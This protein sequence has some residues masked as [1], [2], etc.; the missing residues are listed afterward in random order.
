MRKKVH[1]LFVF[2]AAFPGSIWA[3]DGCAVLEK[4]KATADQFPYRP[5]PFLT[6]D[7]S[8]GVLSL[9]IHVTRYGGPL[10]PGHTLRIGKYMV[11]DVPVFRIAPRDGTKAAVFDPDTGKPVPVSADCLSDA[12]WIFGGTRWQLTQGDRIRITLTS[13]LDYD[14]SSVGTVLKKP[15]N[16]SVPCRAT[17]LHTHGFLVRPT[18]PADPTGLYGDYVLDVTEQKNSATGAT[19]NCGDTIMDHGGHRI[20]PESLRY[21]IAIPGKPGQNGVWTGEHPS[22]LFWYHPH[23][24]GFSRMQTGGGTTGLI[25]IGKLSEYACKQKIGGANCPPAYALSNIRYL[26]LKDAQLSHGTVD[27]VHTLLPEYSTDGCK[28]RPVDANGIPQNS[29]DQTR[30][31]ECAFDQHSGIWVFT[32]NGVQ[33]PVITDVKWN[34][35]EV[36]RIANTSANASY[37]LQL[38]DSTD[39]SRLKAMQVLALDGVSVAQSAGG[40]SMSTNQVLLMPG[41]R[42]EVWL[43]PDAGKTYILRTK[44]INTGSNG[45]GDRWADVDLAEVRWPA[46]PAALSS[47]GHRSPNTV[48]AAAQTLSVYVRGPHDPPATPPTLRAVGAKEVPMSS[49]CRLDAGDERHIL[50]V[51]RVVGD[52]EIFGML[53]GIQRVN[54]DLE[55]FDGTGAVDARGR[56]EVWKKVGAP[57]VPQP[58]PAYGSQ[59]YSNICTVQGRVETWVVENW[60]GEDHNFHVHQ[61]R[62]KLDYTKGHPGNSDYYANPKAKLDGPVGLMDS[63]IA[64]FAPV[65]GPPVTAMMNVYHDSVPVPRGE[66]KCD[67][68]RDLPACQGLAGNDREC[69]G[70][71]ESPHCNPGR[72][73][74]HI[75][76]LRA[77]QVGR[78]VY[79]CHILEHEDGGMMGEI[80]VCGKNDSSCPAAPAHSR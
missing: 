59:P 2:A 53:A 57:D 8:S 13:D 9:D 77:E 15:R 66:S 68:Q 79:H 19:D 12:A 72:I 23:P 28:S 50:I 44:E 80:R 30:R 38:E 6:P 46:Q 7:K 63:L 69:Q 25:T 41:S 5:L 20:S 61:T 29:M 71:V 78:F 3:A 67:L 1:V 22:G 39:R 54:G 24:H 10:D 62:F 73:S 4:F 52:Q 70:D 56:A 21:E 75:G 58:A 32:I 76:F 37:L 33:Y 31:G 64:G 26:E 49:A 74:I 17:N 34:E 47:V 48:P 40:G 14:Q 16:G 45:S 35:D 43:T 42:A 36:W 18:Q 27:A 65:P 60:T 51:R 11:A 55:F